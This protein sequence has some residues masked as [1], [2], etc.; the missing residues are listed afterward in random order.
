MKYVEGPSQPFSCVSER[1]TDPLLAKLQELAD[2]PDGWRF[3]EG[4]PPQPHALDKARAIY[5]RLAF[6]RLKA[7]VFPSADGAVCLVFYAG[8]RCVEIQ[9]SQTGTLDVCVEEGKGFD[10]QEIRNIPDAAMAK[11]VEEGRKLAQRLD[12]WHLSGSFIRENTTQI[13]NVSA[14]HASRIQATGQ[15]YRLLMWNA[16]KNTP[17]PYVVTSNTITTASQ[18]SLSPIGSFQPTYRPVRMSQ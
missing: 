13:L 15:A 4:I 9:V 11:A 17:G 7:D 14:V 5:R 8:E 18:V 2:L 12:T 1:S 10:F 6:L 3:G 16:F